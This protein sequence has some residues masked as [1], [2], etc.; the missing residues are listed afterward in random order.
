MEFLEMNSATESQAKKLQKINVKCATKA[1]RIKQA[2]HN[3]LDELLRRTQKQKIGKKVKADD[4]ICFSLGLLTDDH[5]E[6]IC[7]K[8]LSNKDRMELL[9]QRMAKQRKGLGRDEFFGLL[10]EGKVSI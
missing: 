2:S 4:L 6:Q 7:N 1:I 10:L 3:K 9:F 5:L 8:A